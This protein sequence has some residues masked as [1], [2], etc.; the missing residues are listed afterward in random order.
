MDNGKTSM[1]PL[2]TYRLEYVAF[3]DPTEAEHESIYSA[4]NVDEAVDMLEAE[5][6]C[7]VFLVGWDYA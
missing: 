7:E 2:Y 4:D 1:Q 6:G 5:L 3:G